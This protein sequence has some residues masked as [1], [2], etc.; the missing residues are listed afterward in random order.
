MCRSATIPLQIKAV[1][2]GIVFLVFQAEHLEIVAHQGSAARLLVHGCDNNHTAAARGWRGWQCIR[3]QFE[4]ILLWH[5]GRWACTSWLGFWVRHGFCVCLCCSQAPQGR[6][7][8][9][10]MEVDTTQENMLLQHVPCMLPS[11]VVGCMCSI[12]AGRTRCVQRVY[13]TYLQPIKCLLQ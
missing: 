2:T 8:C 9:H 11:C 4:D 13:S 1:C 12:A 6:Q 7:A 3:W 10:C 5:K